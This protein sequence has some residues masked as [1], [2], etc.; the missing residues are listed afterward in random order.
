MR[1]KKGVR[2]KEHSL[3]ISNYFLIANVHLEKVNIF[4]HIFKA[5]VIILRL[6]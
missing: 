2:Y 3:S 4:M 5:N 1:K 6:A